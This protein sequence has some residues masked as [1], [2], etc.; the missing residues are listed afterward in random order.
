MKKIRTEVKVGIIGVVSIAILFL[1]LNFL[2]GQ[3]FLGKPVTY[4]CITSNLNGII[5]KNAIF[6]NGMKVG[7]VSKISH[8]DPSLQTFLLKFEIDPQVKLPRNSTAEA[9]SRDILGSKAV[10]ILIGDSPQYAESGDTLVWKVSESILGNLQEKLE[11]IAIRAENI[12]ENTDSITL[13]LKNVL[14]PETQNNLI[15]SITNLNTTLDYLAKEKNNIE[16]I[17]SSASRLME[18]LS[19]DS[20]KL[21]HALTN[22]SD[23]SDTIANANLGKTIA[24]LN[25]TLQSVSLAMKRIEKGEGNIGLLLNED[26][27]YY[28]LE[29]TTKNLNLLLED[30]KANPKKYVKISVF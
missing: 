8:I 27:L 9:F 30:I 17:L 2:K 20:K 5:P 18:S 6:I 11:P 24:E 14:N 28:N 12:L 10:Q 3:K 25:S 16:N 13:A 29:N 4:Y 1:G 21:S 22:F 7:V 23:I 19:T 26:S 15:A